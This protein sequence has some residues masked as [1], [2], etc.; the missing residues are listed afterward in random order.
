MHVFSYRRR[1]LHPVQA[2]PGVPEGVVVVAVEQV[3]LRQAP[4]LEHVVLDLPPECEGLQAVL[5]L[6]AVRMGE[7]CSLVT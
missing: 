7:P 2:L 5:K 1:R 4:Q 6:L 3:L